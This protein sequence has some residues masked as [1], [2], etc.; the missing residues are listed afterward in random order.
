M[1]II[2][3]VIHLLIIILNHYHDQLTTYH[4]HLHRWWEHAG[5]KILPCWLLTFLHHGWSLVMKPWSWWWFRWPSSRGALHTRWEPIP[6]QQVSQT[7]PN[8]TKPNQTN[9]D[10]DVQEVSSL[11]RWKLTSAGGRSAKNPSRRFLMK[12]MLILLQHHRHCHPH[13]HQCGWQ[14]CRQWPLKML[15]ILLMKTMQMFEF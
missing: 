11:G 14:W 2:M 15:K 5:D 7:K 13:S 8:Q 3:I 9:D 1:I 6:F 4:H 12:I 10:D